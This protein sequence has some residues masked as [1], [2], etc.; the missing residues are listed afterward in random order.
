MK[1]SKSFRASNLRSGD[2]H[3]FV[4]LERRDR[5][6]ARRNL[7]ICDHAAMERALQDEM[8]ASSKGMEPW[9]SALIRSKEEE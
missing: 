8:N 3:S 1:E 6:Q 9:I 7:N 2:V 4:A 5:V